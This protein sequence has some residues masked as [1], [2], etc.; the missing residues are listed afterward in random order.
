MAPRSETPQRQIVNF[1]KVRQ[2]IVS[3]VR[4][5]VEAVSCATV[6]GEMTEAKWRQ[7]ESMLD[8]EAPEAQ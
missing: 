4:G 6:T 1:G 7:L 5:E 2:A 8:F 3:G